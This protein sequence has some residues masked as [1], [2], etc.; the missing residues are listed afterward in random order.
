MDSAGGSTRA[1]YD[2]MSLLLGHCSFLLLC[3]IVSLLCVVG[4]LLRGIC[5]ICI[6]VMW[7]ILCYGEIYLVSIFRCKA[8][9]D[10]G[11]SE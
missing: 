7:N 4:I 5:V 11:Q 2:K 10:R 9:L 6:T 1:H 8:I 3:S